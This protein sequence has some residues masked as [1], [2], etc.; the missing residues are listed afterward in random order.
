MEYSEKLRD[1]RWQKKRLKIMERD[2]FSCQFCQSKTDTLNVHHI[3]Y[4]GEPW[5]AKDELLITLC[6]SCHEKEEQDL[7]EV[8]NTLF[9]DLKKAGFTSSS[10]HRLGNIFKNTNRGWSKDHLAFDVFKMAVNDDE[11]WRIL[12]ATY[13]RTRESLDH[14]VVDTRRHGFAYDDFGGELAMKKALILSIE[15]KDHWDEEN[16]DF[17]VASTNLHIEEEYGVTPEKREE[18]CGED[19]PFQPIPLK[20]DDC[21]EIEG[22]SHFFATG[23]FSVT[24]IEGGKIY[25]ELTET[26]S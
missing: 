7:K 14:L 13:L 18:V 22:T 16:Y 24:K 9:N 17:G 11:I 12:G 1:P 5:D 3:A 15:M 26:I 19:L 2:N 8:K 23:L 4:E 6:E 21:F 20:I 10:F 25:L